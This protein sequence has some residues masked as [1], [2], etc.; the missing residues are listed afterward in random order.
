MMKGYHAPAQK[1]SKFCIIIRK[2]P[3]KSRVNFHKNEY[4]KG[5][6]VYIFIICG[7]SAAPKPPFQAT[8]SMLYFI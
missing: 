4:F 2:S 8:S 7:C 1:A 6:F 5:I 3:R